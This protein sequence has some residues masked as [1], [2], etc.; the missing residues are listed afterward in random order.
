MAVIAA[1]EYILKDLVTAR[2]AYRCEKFIRPA[3][4]IDWLN[5]TGLREQHG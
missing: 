5:N 4:L 3:E 1:A 2:D